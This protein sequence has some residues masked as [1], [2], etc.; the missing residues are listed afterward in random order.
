MGESGEASDLRFVDRLRD[1]IGRF[2]DRVRYGPV[3]A[4]TGT[5]D[6]EK[7]MQEL[8]ESV[9]DDKPITMDKET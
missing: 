6:Q 3:V 7:A 2:V 1:G 9:V 4:K 8:H 5:K